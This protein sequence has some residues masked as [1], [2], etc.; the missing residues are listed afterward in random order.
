M[1]QVISI[2]LW[3]RIAKL[4]SKSNRR[5]AAIAY[6][7]NERAIRFGEGDTLIV[8][9]SEQAVACGQTSALLLKH[10]YQNGAK[11]Y[12]LAGLHAK[13]LLLDDVAVIGSANLSSSS[14]NELVEAAILTDHPAAVATTRAFIEAVMKKAAPVDGKDLVRLGSIKV[15]RRFLRATVRAAAKQVSIPVAAHRTWLASVTRLDES[16]FEDESERAERGLEE[17]R[18]LLNKKSSD[19]NWIRYPSDQ[20]R[21][22]KEAKQGDSVIQIWNE[23]H[24]DK[25][26]AA[27]YFHTPILMRRREPTCIRIYLEEAASSE[28]TALTWRQFLRL[29]KQVG[30]PFKVS[31]HSLRVIPDNY[32]DALAALWKRQQRHNG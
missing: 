16:R 14:A 23:S 21:F 31:P 8:D 25:I 12:S 32:S 3:K 13:V 29:T 9:A 27:V 20:T 28:R 5:M 7:T 22:V 30:L 10:A 24:K 4:A 11:I 19:A 15:N 2:G 6:A 18:Q 26:P 17:A 1:N